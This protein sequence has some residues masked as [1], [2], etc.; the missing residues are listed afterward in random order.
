MKRT[1]IKILT[2]LSLFVALAAKAQDST[3]L[4]KEVITREFSVS[5]GGVDSPDYRE[6]VSREASVFVGGDPS[7][8][9][10]EVVSREVS[11]VVAA[12]N[13][14]APVSGLIVTMS[15]GGGTVTLSWAGYNQWA[16]LDVAGYAIYLSAQALT[17]V[18]GMTP[19]TN[20]PGETLSVTL[21]GLPAGRELFF[22][23]VP[24][25]VT[26]SFGAEV[27]FS[28]AYPVSREVVSRE[29]SVFIGGDPTPSSQEIVSR[30]MTVVVT[31]PGA[32]APITQLTVTNSPD[33]GS[34]LLSWTGYNQ[35]AQ[36][37]VASYNIYLSDLAF[38]NISG[39]TPYTS[40]PGETLSVALTGLPAG[41]DHFF[42]VVPV[43][44]GG[45]SN[46]AVNFTA[47]YD[48]AREVVSRETSIYIGG[49]AGDTYHE[50]VS[51][52]VSF[53]VATTNPPVPVT[54]L[55]SG[56]LAGTSTNAYGAI[57]LDWS[58]YDFLAQMDV[59]SY[60]VYVGSSFYSD[61]TGLTPYLYVP[62]ETTHCTLSG[63]NALGVYYVAVVAEDVLGNFATTVRSVS[64]QASVGALG[65]VGNLRV[66]CGTNFL[67]F[68]WTPPVGASSFLA[69]Y[70]IYLAGT[71]VPLTLPPNATGF[72]AI[73]LLPATSYPMR[74]ATVDRF[75]QESSGVSLLAATLF[76][77]P[78]NVM[79]RALNGVVNLAWDNV[80]PLQLLQVYAVY[81]SATNFTSPAG[82]VP[83]LETHANQANIGNLVNG[84]TYYFGVTAINVAGGES[85]S[86][87]T[88]A[89]TPNVVSI[90]SAALQI[91]IS[92]SIT[93][94]NP[95]GMVSYAITVTNSGATNLSGVVMNNQLA[96][97]LEL[98]DVTYGRGSADL[99][100]TSITWSLGD[101]GTN[102]YATMAVLVDAPRAGVMTNLFSAADSG[103]LAEAG[104]V[105]VFYVGVAQPVLLSVSVLDQQVVVSWPVSPSGFNLESA[106]LLQGVP[107]W[108]SVTNTP[109][110]VGD[111]LKVTFPPGGIAQFYRLIKTP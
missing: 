17:T 36:S 9:S 94:L 46:P 72:N 90:P 64:A 105:Q 44:A 66:V 34:V 3:L 4:A 15:P 108:S 71:N 76:T 93:N 77:A 40:F 26:G 104:A 81:M 110:V 67:D 96:S 32:P 8:A 91:L 47:A 33:G 10:A 41:V 23:V 68:L 43:S 58:A 60:R 79:A 95:G 89:A 21:T 86:S 49:D 1:C 42:A 99:G 101:L 70:N 57:D 55:N 69:A 12:T 38:T 6:I 2:A 92:P 109:V 97:G 111:Q 18:S 65:E 11:F 87:Q 75:G 88:V 62:A 31:L 83:V 39:M 84:Q 7:P 35:W 30:E 14:P 73:G 102:A 98:E 85:A 37:D 80:Q 13:A 74:I 59:V 29:A 56:F 24:V 22:A 103:G 20:V 107:N 106:T 52:E 78:I 63:L 53:V 100:G 51:R 48:L 28:G 54:G 19:L 82:L 50:L 61:V 16:Q 45:L 25:D 5:V 27:N